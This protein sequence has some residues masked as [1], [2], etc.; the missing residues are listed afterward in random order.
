LGWNSEYG[1]TEVEPGIIANL[2][3]DSGVSQAEI[4]QTLKDAGFDLREIADAVDDEVTIDEQGNTLG[5]V[6]TAIALWNSGYGGDQLDSR[7][8][9]DILWDE[10]ATEIDIAQASK[11]LGFDLPTIADAIKFGVTKSDG[12]ELNYTS[13]AVGLW[14]SGYS[15]DELNSRILADILWDTGAS[16]AQI[17]QAL[18]YGIG[19]NLREIA[20]DIK[21]GVTKSDGTELN[22]TDVAVGLWNSGIETDTYE[23][24]DI[25]WDKGATVNQIGQALNNGI[26]RNLREIA[27]D[28]KYGVTKSDGTELNYTSVAVG[29]WNSGLSIDLRQLADILWD[30]GASQEEIGQALNY[31]IGRNLREIAD[32]LDD[33]NTG[34]NYTDVAIGLWN[35]GLAIGSRQLADILWDE[36]ASQEEIGQALN[37]GIGRNLREIASDIKYGVTKRDGTGLN[38]ADVAI[39]LWNSGLAIDS[40]ILADILWDTGASEAQIGQALNF[41]IGLNLRQIADALDDGNT[42]FNYTDVAIGLWNSGLA[43]DSRQLTDILWDEG[44]SQAQIGQALN[45]GIGLNLR[46]IASDIKYGVTKRDGTGLNYTD[47][48]VGLWNS[49]IETDTYEI[50]DILWDTGASQAQIGQALNYGIGRNLSQIASDM[51][52]GV[53]L[54][55]GKGFNYY[56][57][58]DGLWNSGLAVN[59]RDIARELQNLGANAIDTAQV[60]HYEL[61]SSL[62]VI[63][64]A[65]DDGATFSYRNVADGLW[66]SGHGISDYRLSRLLRNEGAD[67]WTTVE[68]VDAVA[69]NYARAVY[70]TVKGE[71]KDFFNDAS[72]QVS[73]FTQKVENFYEDNKSTLLV[74]FPAGVIAVEAAKS[75]AESI[76][77]GKIDPIVDALKRIPVAGTAVGII[78]GVINAIE[79]D[80]KGVLKSAIDSALAFYGASNAITPKMVDFAVDVFWEVKDSDY[81]EAVSESLNN[82]GLSKTVADVFVSVAWALENGNWETAVNAALTKVGFNNA[83]E[84]VDIAWDVIDKNYQGMLKTGL[85]LVGYNTLGIDR[86]KA[87]AFVNIT[88]AIKDG[89]SSKAAD[90]LISLA[91][92]NAL[93][94]SQSNWVKDLRDGNSSNDRLAIQTGLSELGFK[95]A[96][97]WT[98]TIW[99]VKDGQY[100]NALSETLSLGNFKNAQDWRNIIDNLQKENYLDALST[101][102]KLAGFKDGQS[103]A[104]AALAV[105][106]KDYIDA[107]YESFDLIEGGSDLKDAFKALKEN[108]LQEFVK[109][110]IDAAPLLIRV[111][112]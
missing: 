62:E 48:A 11:Y 68:A 89:N 99:A 93:Q 107:F 112:L 32:A 108:Q 40:R 47:V 90:Y 102:F 85:E 92:S 76:K 104:E 88:T 98:S 17:G 78:E 5:Y 12:T 43:I 59:T 28:I 46:E 6:D 97:Q 65:L 14:N 4:G 49:G 44:A 25:L 2:L 52:Y 71:I 53:T 21:Y 63:A 58:A 18:N 61:D 80:E 72:K 45:Y 23:I 82:L 57:I 3:W 41:E 95:N 35:S 7:I 1:N 19:R 111:L 86:A 91:G 42:G 33:G 73:R 20:S 106:D 74:V 30:T 55:N 110:M 13:V 26:G 29:L 37:Y 67:F 79:G 51:K 56:D 38:Y 39:G 54:S 8:L 101:A 100:L 94:I 109:S 16:Q 77:S 60:L 83:K 15:V 96:A 22:Y 105:R 36:G 75:V 66:N 9:A 103:L 69:T 64:D 10:G 50:A 31:G 84:F 27:S 81:Q 34:F 87:D 24:A 70:V